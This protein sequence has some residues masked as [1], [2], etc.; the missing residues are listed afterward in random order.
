MQ[1]QYFMVSVLKSAVWNS[2]LFP[3]RG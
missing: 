2:F 3:A 1:L